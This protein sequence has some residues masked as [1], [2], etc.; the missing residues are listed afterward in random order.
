V[1]LTVDGKTYTQPL[2]LRLDPR[3]KTPPPPRVAGLRQLAA[4][5][6]E[7]YDSARVAHA[8][9]REARRLA[10]SVPAL[11]VRIDSIA[12][13]PAAPLSAARRGGQGVRSPTL[14]SAS[15]AALA[16]AMA[17][18]DADVTPTAAQVAAC[19]RARAQVHAVMTRWKQLRRT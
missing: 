17:L 15:Q 19:A 9:Y 16:A 5:T 11:A 2:A 3:V 13:P 14:E 1:R 12:P 10:D 18:Q 4:L 7:M 6:Q 8:A